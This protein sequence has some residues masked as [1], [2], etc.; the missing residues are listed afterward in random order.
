LAGGT[1]QKKKGRE[2]L[3]PESG[4]NRRKVKRLLEGIPLPSD[5]K[6]RVG[7]KSMESKL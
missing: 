3:V 2:H 4:R 1:V 5:R 6:L 7:D